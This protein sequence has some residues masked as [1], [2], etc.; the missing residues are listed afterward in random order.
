LQNGDHLTLAE[1]ERRFDATPNLK[2]AELIE[3]VV[4]MPPPVSVDHGSLMASWPL[5]L[6]FIQ[7]RRL[8]Q[9]AAVMRPFA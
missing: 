3:G 5:F 8:G 9:I 2:K 7:R 6:S 4:Y 1:F